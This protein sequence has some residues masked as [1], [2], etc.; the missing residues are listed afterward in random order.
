MRILV[1]GATGRVGNEVVKVLLL[2][3]AAVRALTRKQPRPGV[4][5]DVVEV[6]L[7]DLNDPVSIAKAMKGVDKLFLLIGSESVPVE[8]TQALIAYGLAKRSGLRHVTYVSVY[9][10][11]QFIEVP[12][13]TKPG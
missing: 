6:V 3:G 13:L 4:F 1:I 11:D 2:R 8:L 5:P 9:K 12:L 7:G 10:A